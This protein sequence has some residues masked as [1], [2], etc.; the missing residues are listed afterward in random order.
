MNYMDPI[1]SVVG[2]VV[3]SGVG[4][5]VG[6]TL[7][8]T[9]P[10]DATRVKKI[11]MGIGAFALGS[12]V[13]AKVVEYVDEQLDDVNNNVRKL[14]KIDKEDVAEAV[15]EV[16]TGLVAAADTLKDAASEES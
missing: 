2:F 7:R 3:S 11:V 12:A 9:I 10:E 1:K 16:K 14:L 8:N 13:S 4:S 5:I 15:G 6:Q